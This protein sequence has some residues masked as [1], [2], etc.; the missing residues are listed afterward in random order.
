MINVEKIKRHHKKFLENHDAMVREAVDEQK[1]TG[2]AQR[3]VND[4][5]GL[6]MRTGNLRR[7]TKVKTFIRTKGGAMVRVSNDAK[8]AWAQ[9][10]GSGLHGHKRAKYMIKGNPFL[11]F[12]WKGHLTFRRYVMHPGVRQTRFL[13][14]TT[15]ALGRVTAHF[16]RAKMATVA[17][18]F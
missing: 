14:N 18:K 8:Y 9:D 17:H 12:V 1:L 13:Y 5:S 15:D 2:L 4:N 6:K 7:R 3:Y 10:Q 16:L 11:R